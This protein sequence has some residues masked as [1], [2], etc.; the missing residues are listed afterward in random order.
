VDQ[1]LTWFAGVTREEALT[2]LKFAESSV[3]VQ[4]S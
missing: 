1:F 2:V 3:A 4:M